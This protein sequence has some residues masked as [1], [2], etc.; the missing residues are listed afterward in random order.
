MTK[1]RAEKE[2]DI[3]SAIVRSLTQ[4]GW[5]VIRLLSSNT[6][7]WPDLLVIRG[8]RVIFLEVKR[9]GESPTPIQHMRHAELRRQGISVAVVRSVQEAEEA[10]TSPCPLRSPTPPPA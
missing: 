7:G 4:E 3:Q 1:K 2:S 5:T 6:R 10:C 9:P 8:G